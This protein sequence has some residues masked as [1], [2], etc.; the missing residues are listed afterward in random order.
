[1]GRARGAR[2]GTGDGCDKATAA[3]DREARRSRGHRAGRPQD[4]SDD[5]TAC[6]TR[7]PSIAGRRQHPQHPRRQTVAAGHAV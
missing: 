7:A 6:R 5:R 1:A 2:A 4:A 3:S